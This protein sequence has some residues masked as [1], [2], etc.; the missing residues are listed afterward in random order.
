MFLYMLCFMILTGWVLI[1]WR[2]IMP[3]PVRRRYKVL[4]MVLLGCALLLYH[5]ASVLVRQGLPVEL[6]ASLRWVGYM[7]L[8]F[9]SLTI[10]LLFTKELVLGMSSIADWFSRRKSGR[11][12]DGARRAFLQNAGN[13]AVLT[14]VFPTVAFSINQAFEAPVVKRVPLYVDG[15]HSDLEGLT[16]V[17]VSDL[18]VGSILDAKWLDKLVRQIEGLNPDIFVLTGDAIDGKVSRVG[19]ELVGLKEISPKFGKFFVTGN[20]E[21]YSGVDG[22][23]EHMRLLDFTV[24][25]NQHFLVKKGD[26]GLLIAG[27]WDY[28][29]GRFGKQYESDPFAAKAGAPEHDVSVLL[30][31]RPKNIFK[32]EQAGFDI[33]L[34]GHTHG[35]QYF[36][37]T[38]AVRLFQP[39]VEGLHQ[40]GKTSL[41]VNTGTGFWGP[42]MRLTVP[43]EITLFTLTGSSNTVV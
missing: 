42:P 26:A 22:W 38:Y 30:A 39:Y 16:I 7:S 43:P 17:Q 27:V 23:V 34:S 3:L 35:G 19:K 29:G 4:L 14:A 6:N 32:A 2:M 41:Y 28:H 13:A 10:P 8:G 12:I 15:L 25:N 31:H 5:V 37:W 18:H 24:L 21:F 36:P 1:C 33:Q 11:P 9:A 20:H 40:V